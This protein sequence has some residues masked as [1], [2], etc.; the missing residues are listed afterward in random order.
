M[1]N[2]AADIDQVVAREDAPGQELKEIQ[3]RLLTARDD[4]KDAW[5]NFETIGGDDSAAKDA[6]ARQEALAEIQHEAEQYVRIRSST[7]LLR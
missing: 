1:R 6:A 3:N 7:I 5:T 4:L 2:A